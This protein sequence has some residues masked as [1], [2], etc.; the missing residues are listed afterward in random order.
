MPFRS[1]DDAMKKPGLVDSHIHLTDYD[2]GTDIGAIV[3]ESRAVGVTHLV[4]NGTSEKD[5][6][7]VLDVAS[8]YEGV[9][10]CLGLHPWFVPDRSA[11][12]LDV[13]EGLVRATGCGIGET[14]LD[15]CVESLDKSAQEEAFRAQLDLARRYD[16][17]ITIHCVRSWGWLSDVLATESALPGRML[18][19][20]YGGSAD[21]VRRMSAFGV[22]FSFSGK[23]LDASHEKAR[24]A[25]R[26]IPPGRLLI[27]TDAPSLLPPEP[28]CAYTVMARD[29]RIHNHPANLPAIL[30]GIAELL[31]EPADELRGRI[32]DNAL[33][34]HG[35]SL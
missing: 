3:E 23:V 7:E 31:G 8:V 10:P 17:P 2:D 22:Y 1:F 5:W 14:G 18:L 4:C 27:E 21:M 29:G 28:Y 13:L 35:D 11:S 32:W 16:R 15:K 34:F 30:A 24:V 33:R 20:A 12:W 19:H 6:R 26:A 25:L 9:L